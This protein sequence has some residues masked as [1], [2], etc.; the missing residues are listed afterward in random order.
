MTARKATRWLIAYSRPTQPWGPKPKVRKCLLQDTSSR[1]SS[2]KRSGSNLCASLKPCTKKGNNK[3][4]ILG[5]VKCGKCEERREMTSRR[6]SEKRSVSSLR[7]GLKPS[8]KLGMMWNGGTE[9]GQVLWHRWPSCTA[10]VRCGIN[11][12]KRQGAGEHAAMQQVTLIPQLCSRHCSADLH[13]G[14]GDGRHDEGALAHHVVICH[15]EVVLRNLRSTSSRQ[16][17]DLST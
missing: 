13:G 6:S 17:G 12:C 9:W 8:R 14:G 3:N 15:P 4:R 16:V 2:E 7:S 10:C 1:R 5:N 11:R